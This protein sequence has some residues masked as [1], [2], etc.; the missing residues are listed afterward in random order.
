M[1]RLHL[2]RHVRS[3]FGFRIWGNSCGAVLL[4]AV[5]RQ[6]H[7]TAARLRATAYLATSP[8]RCPGAQPCRSACPTS[9]PKMCLAATV[10]LP[11]QMFGFCRVVAVVVFAMAYFPCAQNLLLRDSA[12][13]LQE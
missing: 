8:S 7:L 3:P 1:T 6:K 13:L 10:P 9:T 11:T 2:K 12:L 5:T 4:H